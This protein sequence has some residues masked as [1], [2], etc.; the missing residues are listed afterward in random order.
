MQTGRLNESIGLD[1][2]ESTL[3]QGPVLLLPAVSTPDLSLSMT[4][5]T[6]L[7]KPGLHDAVPE[8]LGK[9]QIYY[10]WAQLSEH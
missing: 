2:G 6:S 4:S 8:R 7:Q 10:G 5:L 9:S 1:R 3:N